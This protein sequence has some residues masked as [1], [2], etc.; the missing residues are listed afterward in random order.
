MAK[1]IVYDPGGDCH[2]VSFA[3]YR[4]REILSTEAARGIVVSF[5]ASRLGVTEGKCLGFV[6][7]PDHVHALVWFSQAG[8]LSRFLQLWKGS[9]SMALKEHLRRDRPRYAA[10][11]APCDAV[12]QPKYHDFNVRT[13]A[14]LLEK[15]E[16][17]HGNPVRVG[18]V[19]KAQDWRWSSAR[20]YLLEKPV[21]VPIGW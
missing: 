3:C 10:T 14:K 21:G 1:R 15:L 4:R 17:M 20:W 13:E 6:V 16:Y 11:I 7:M 12:W 2:F 19:E 18:L 8:R 5:L 9:S